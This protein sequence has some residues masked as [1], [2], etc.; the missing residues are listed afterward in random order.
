VFPP[1]GGG[2]EECREVAGT[3]QKP[4][5]PVAGAQ[6][7]DAARLVGTRRIPSIDPPFVSIGPF[8]S[9]GPSESIGTE[10]GHL[11]P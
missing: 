5:A 2:V 3:D 4:V 10:H 8:E 11:C 6:L 1:A 7:E 9:I